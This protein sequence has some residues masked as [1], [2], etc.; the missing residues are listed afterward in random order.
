[1]LSISSAPSADDFLPCL[2]FVIIQASPEQLIVD[3]E[4]V[5]TFAHPKQL[6]GHNAYYF[7]HFL[8]AL[9]FIENIDGPS[10]GMDPFCFEKFDSNLLL[11]KHLG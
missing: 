2:I 4:F 8:S 5:N 3:A 6:N 7:T 10:L 1:M 11:L 9:S